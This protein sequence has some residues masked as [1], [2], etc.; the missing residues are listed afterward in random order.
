MIIPADR[1]GEED[2]VLETI[3]AGRAVTHFETMRQRKDGTP[4]RRS[5]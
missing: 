3:R 2:T 1:Q 5:R 4:D